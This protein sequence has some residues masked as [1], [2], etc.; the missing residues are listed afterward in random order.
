MYL[1]A[2]VQ[3][4]VLSDLRAAAKVIEGKKVHATVTAIVVPGSLT[5]KKQAEEEGLDKIFIDAGFEWRES[6]CQYVLSD[7]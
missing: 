6:G 2:H 1:S 4:H 5:V 3:I 7:E